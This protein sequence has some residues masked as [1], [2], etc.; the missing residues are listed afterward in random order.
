MSFQIF[1]TISRGEFLT[2]KY[3]SQKLMLPE[4][5]KI[6]IRHC[7]AI[8]IKFGGINFVKE[9]TN[10]TTIVQPINRIFNFV[11]SLCTFTQFQI[12]QF[13]LCIE[14]FQQK[15]AMNFDLVVN[16]LEIAILLFLPWPASAQSFNCNN[17]FSSSNLSCLHIKYSSQ[18]AFQENFHFQNYAQ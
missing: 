9:W 2:Q 6:N 15:S 12:V 11:F 8:S 18:L 5:D 13:E 10:T 17:V 7:L 16:I 4:N 3:I 1:Q 14:P